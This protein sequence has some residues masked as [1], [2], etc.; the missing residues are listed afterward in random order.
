MGLILVLWE[1]KYLQE[2]I[3]ADKTGC[4]TLVE[5]LTN[6]NMQDVLLEE[7]TSQKA[8][9]HSSEDGID[10]L[11]DVRHCWRK[12]AKVSDIVCW[13]NVTHRVLHVE[14]VT[15]AD[16]RISQKHELV[17]VRRIYEYYQPSM[18]RTLG[19]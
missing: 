14:T 17:G 1:K 9:I 13:G 15:K 11:I 3:S 2:I 8:V 6:E 5:K 10:I 4:A 19:M 7:I 18:R 16:E 12:N